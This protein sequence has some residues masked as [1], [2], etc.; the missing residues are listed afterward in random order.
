MHLTFHQ[1]GNPAEV[2]R[3]EDSAAPLP[4]R[5]EV[6]VRLLYAPINPADLNYIEGNYGKVPTLPAT[7]G[8]E[9]CGRVEAIGN[10]VDSLAVGDLV[11]PLHSLGSWSQWVLAAENQFAKLPEGIDPVQGSML[12]VN[13]ATAWQLLHEF[14]DLCKGDW[15]VQNAANSGVGRAVIQIAKQLG[16][17][18]MN[19]VRRKE[20]VEELT[21]LGA[22]LVLQDTDE[23]LEAARELL[24]SHP[25]Q[26]GLNAVGGDSA[27]RLMKLL[28]PEAALVTYGAMSRR[29]L[30]VPNKFLIFKGLELRGYW[31][32]RWMEKASHG[33]VE[34]VLQPLARM[35]LARE[36]QLPVEHIYPIAEFAEAMR[37]A[38]KSERS[39][40]ILL[41]F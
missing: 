12:R 33:D 10:E 11:I 30:K 36:L 20:L 31:L 35:M 17:R 32:S 6:C 34:D 23:G 28:S 8:N 19:F 14:R 24:G 9:G 38:Q 13:P 15:V 7:P 40:K 25:L 16:L 4:Q 26:L 39:G 22:D 37:H 2:L 29:S 41:S 1:T 18:T 21:S 5:H 3:L 27:V